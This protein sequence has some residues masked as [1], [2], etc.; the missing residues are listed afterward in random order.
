[1]RLIFR[2]GRHPWRPEKNK[3]VSCTKNQ[4]VGECLGAPENERL[5]FVKT[6]DS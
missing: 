1:M 3:R 4:P 6:G 5:S 2:R